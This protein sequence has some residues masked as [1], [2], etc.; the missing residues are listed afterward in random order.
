[1]PIEKSVLDEIHHYIKEFAKNNIDLRI[2]LEEGD[3]WI[4]R[5]NLDTTGGTISSRAVR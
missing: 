3:R 2:I 1:M 4:A 5:F